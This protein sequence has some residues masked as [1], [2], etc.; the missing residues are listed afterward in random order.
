MS[1][2]Q[3]LYVC[4]GQAG[5]IIAFLIKTLWQGNKSEMKDLKQ[6][7]LVNS[8]VTNQNTIAVTKLTVQM[9]SVV[10]KLDI[11]GE[12]RRDVDKMGASMRSKGNGE[13]H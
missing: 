6:S 5:L 4:L 2:D 10:E 7:I 13:N 11:V 8:N 12:L 9:E 3:L 1:Q